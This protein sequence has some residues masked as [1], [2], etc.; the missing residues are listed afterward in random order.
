MKRSMHGWCGAAL[1]LLVVAVCPSPTWAEAIKI[2]T[3][4]TAGG[5]PLYVAKDRG[6]FSAEGLDAELVPFDAGQPVA[7]AVVAGAIDFGSAGVTSALYTL[8]GQG[9]LRIISGATYDNAE[10]HA[11]AIVASNAAYAA[12]LVSVKD[13]AGR[14]VGLT[15]IGSTY[16]YALAIVAEKYGIDLKSMR[17]LPLQSFSNL[18]SAV[19]GGQTDAAVMTTASALPLL[20]ADKARLVAWVGDEVPWQVSAV[21]ASTKT[22]TERRD[23]VQR[24]LRA[25]RKGAQDCYVATVGARGERK[26]GP[27]APAIL[28]IVAHYTGL[29]VA[30]VEGSIGYTDPELRIDEK[31]IRR[32][33]EWYRSQGMIKG[34][35]ALDRV[36]DP[37]YVV[38]LP[39]G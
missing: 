2:G 16:H 11:A 26:D 17:T 35:V 1:G 6:Y 24:F 29:T 34:D 23:T 4:L 37:S 15:Q 12:G 3:L 5:G 20:A 33:I 18:A 27:D 8:A 21:W 31:D 10:F 30:Q 22:A 14:T 7:V 39:S 13:L 38:A 28:G 9:A 32:Q 25:V 36:L 19:T